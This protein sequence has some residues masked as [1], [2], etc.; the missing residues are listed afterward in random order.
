MAYEP[1]LNQKY[2]SHDLKDSHPGNLDNFSICLLKI[3]EVW[4]EYTQ[5]LKM[6]KET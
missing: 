1:M 5:I 6:V 3:D 2:Q 4:P